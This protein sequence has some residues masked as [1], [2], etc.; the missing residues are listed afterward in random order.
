MGREKMGQFSS[1]QIIGFGM[2]LGFALLVCLAV[3][4]GGFILTSGIVDSSHPT[5]PPLVFPTNPT[6]TPTPWPPPASPSPLSPSRPAPEGKIVYVC[7]V[8][9]LQASDQIC[10][11]D[12]DGT[13]Q[14]RI[15]TS[16]NAR[17]YYPSFAP[18]GKSV[19]FSSNMD[20]NF[21]IYEMDLTG[22]LTRFWQPGIAPEVSP[23]NRSIVFTQGNGV[24]DTL[25]LMDRD[26]QNPR[27][28]YSNGWDPTWSPDG[29]RIL[30]ATFLR[31]DVVQLMSINL[32]GSNP[33]QVTDLPLLRGRSDWS[34]DGLFITTYSGRPWNR[35]VYLVN[36]D[37]SGA[38]PIT[39]A[40]GNGQ[41]PSFSPDGQWVAFTAYYDHPGQDNGCEIY[42]IRIDGTDLTRLTDNDYCDW[43][44][45]W[46]P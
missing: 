39:E 36:A 33:R 40:G 22:A 20:G 10:V 18:D 28:L 31:E 2:G 13:G 35:Q 12:A 16:D 37:G 1:K 42:I 45:R 25:W 38:R 43:Q 15:T 11:I 14:R 9:K 34:A 3:G 26:G 24:N 27:Q 29:T 41:G 30:F 46:G 32:D 8:F 17:H 21:E 4:L 44:P 6:G 7:Q 23:D 19:L 5:S